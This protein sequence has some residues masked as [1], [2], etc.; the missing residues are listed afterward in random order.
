MLGMLLLWHE[1]PQLCVHAVLYDMQY[2]DGV[3]IGLSWV[4]SAW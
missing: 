2:V 1:Q 4:I 3:S